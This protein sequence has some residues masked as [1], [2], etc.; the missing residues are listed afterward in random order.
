MGIRDWIEG[1]WR[2]MDGHGRELMMVGCWAVW[3]VRNKVIFEG[4]GVV[5]REI[6]SR[7]CSVMEE[8]E[9][10]RELEL[11]VGGRKGHGE[12]VKGSGGWQVPEPG[13]VKLN[14]DVGVKE[15][16]GVGVGG[17]CRDETRKVLWGM[18]VFRKENWDPRIA[19]VVAILDGL[20][21]AAAAGHDAVVVESDCLE[22]IEALQ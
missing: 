6:I 19:E 9:G 5:G 2:E 7:V 8:I 1:R 3:E 22:V 20:E 17:V 4:N 11:T 13:L 15:G 10:G 21:E 14:V 12:V 16:V 18:S